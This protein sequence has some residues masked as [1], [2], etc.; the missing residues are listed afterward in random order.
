MLVRVKSDLQSFVVVGDI[1]VP[2]HDIRAVDAFGQFLEDFKPSTL[3]LNGDIFEFKSCSMHGGGD[4]WGLDVEA[5]FDV[6]KRFLRRIRRAAGDDCDIKFN[7]GNH[8]TRPRRLIA[9]VLPQL[10]NLKKVTSMQDALDMSEQGISY[11]KELD[12]PIR[13]GKLIIIHGHQQS[14][15]K[16]KG[17]MLPVHHAKKMAELYGLPGHT[18]VYGHSHKE[19]IHA[20]NQYHGNMKAIGLGCMARL[21]PKWTDARTGGWVHQFGYG[22]VLP[23][24]ETYFYPVTIYNGTFVANGAQYTG[25]GPEC[26]KFSIAWGT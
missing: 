5:E 14:V 9:D 23:G 16:K 3:I 24:G 4:A 11:T 13:L 7:E 17:G 22:Y 25:R 1:H 26:K 2:D 19:Q 18:V 20:V 6:N 8:E 10:Q 12:Q 21:D 15:G